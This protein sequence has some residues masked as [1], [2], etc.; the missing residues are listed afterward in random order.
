MTNRRT[1]LLLVALAAAGCTSTPEPARETTTT[2]PASAKPT[3]FGTVRTKP[4]E[5][6][7]SDPAAPGGPVPD[8]ATTDD[9][10]A[11]A[12]AALLT[13]G[14]WV[15]GSTLEEREWRDKLNATLTPSGQDSASTTWGYRIRDTEITGDPEIIRA[16]A[17]SA[18]VR[19]TTNYTSYEVTVVKTDTGEWLT[20]HLT[21][22]TTEG[23]DR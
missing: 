17:G 10:T 8:D 19:I 2:Q 13:M 4:D 18:V 3:E 23:A 12:E 15:Q 16:N 9:E 14:I 5:Y 6:D 1:L 7:N 21:T 11:A 22:V 20:S